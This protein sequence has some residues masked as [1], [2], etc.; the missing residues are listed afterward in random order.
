MASAV[1]DSPLRL[2]RASL[3]PLPAPRCAAQPTVAESISPDTH[4][5][6]RRAHAPQA[7]VPVR[8][9]RLS[10]HGEA[11]V[12]P[13]HTGRTLCGA[14][15]DAFSNASGDRCVR[16]EVYLAPR[17]ARLSAGPTRTPFQSLVRGS[18]IGVLSNGSGREGLHEPLREVNMEGKADDLKGHAKEAVG[19]LTDDD[20]LKREGKADRLGQGEREARRREGLGRGQGRRRDGQVE[21]TDFAFVRV[22]VRLRGLAAVSATAPGSTTL[23]LYRHTTLRDYRFSG[24]AIEWS[25]QPTMCWTSPPQQFATTRVTR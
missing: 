5:R 18:A 11:H 3:H 25:G 9:I 13:R 23:T 1:V 19:D 6:A 4:V 22:A 21:R 15:P 2:R 16:A 12:L 20:D 8:L 14:G 24:A 10:A 17:A 7:D